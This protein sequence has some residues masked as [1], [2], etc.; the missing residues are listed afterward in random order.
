MTEKSYGPPTAYEFWKGMN[1]CKRGVLRNG[2]VVPIGWESD[3]RVVCPS[4][5]TFYW[6][7]LCCQAARL[8]HLYRWMVWQCNHIIIRDT[9]AENFISSTSC[10]AMLQR[11]YWWNDVNHKWYVTLFWYADA[12]GDV[13]P[14][15]HIYLPTLSEIMVCPLLFSMALHRAKLNLYS[16]TRKFYFSTFFIAMRT[17]MCSIAV[18]FLTMKKWGISVSVS[19]TDPEAMLLSHSM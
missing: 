4:I 6:E 18:I 10:K 1:W 14:G 7:A 11:K 15:L 5:R 9:L 16:C 13:L 17:S 12:F 19:F 3:K 8:E 2:I